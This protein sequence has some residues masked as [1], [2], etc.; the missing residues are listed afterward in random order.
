MYAVLLYCVDAV[1]RIRL[2]SNQ[3]S[4]IQSLAM[5]AGLAHINATRPLDW[6]DPQ[7]TAQ[8]LPVWGPPVNHM[9]ARPDRFSKVN[10]RT[11]T[12]LSGVTQQRLI[13]P[14]WTASYE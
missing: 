14:F 10:N 7:G 1:H 6:Q 2:A 12:R 5:A 9:R 11:G 3:K 13:A 4:E 8:R